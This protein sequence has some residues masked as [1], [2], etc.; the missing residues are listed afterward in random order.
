MEAEEGFA[1]TIVE[2]DDPSIRI[3]RRTEIYERIQRDGSGMP[4]D[5]GADER[6]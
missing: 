5:I 6:S 3:D 4:E 2:S 1:D